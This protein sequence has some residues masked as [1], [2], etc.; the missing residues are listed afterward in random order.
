[1]QGSV[2]ELGRCAVENEGGRSGS[3]DGKFEWE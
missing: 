1:M 2:D 3:E